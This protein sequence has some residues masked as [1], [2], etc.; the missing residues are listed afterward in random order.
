MAQQ[1]Q[2]VLFCVLASL[3]HSISYVGTFYSSS[4][5]PA[6]LCSV[7]LGLLWGGNALAG[8]L[9][10]S[11]LTKSLGLRASLVLSFS[12][13]AVQMGCL[14]YSIAVPSIGWPLSVCGSLYAG[15]TSAIW[16]DCQALVVEGACAVQSSADRGMALTSIRSN[17]NAVWTFTYQGVNMIIFLSLTFLMY[18]FDAP[19]PLLIFAL[20]VVGIV[21]TMV[22]VVL[23]I[24]GHVSAKPADSQSPRSTP[25]PSVDTKILHGTGLQIDS[26]RRSGADDGSHAP[27][28][29]W[30]VLALFATDYRCALLA[31]TQL[32]FGIAT[33]LF[34]F[35]VNATLI[36]GRSS[37][38]DDGNDVGVL[39]LGLLEAFAYLVS[40]LAAFPYSYFVKRYNALTLIMVWGN[41]SF[42]LAALFVLCVP[43]FR[44]KQWS[45]LLLLKGLYGA[46]RGVFEGENRSYY[47]AMFRGEKLVAAFSQ[48][49]FLTGLSGGVFFLLAALLS[50]AALSA[51]ACANGLL[52]MACMVLLARGVARRPV[53]P[54]DSKI[55]EDWG[56]HTLFAGVAGAEEND[57]YYSRLTDDEDIQ[58]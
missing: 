32:S 5:L 31:P 19:L 15:A 43:V 46:G 18:S 16:W 55:E 54:D 42:V 17:L 11:W 9:I 38:G 34:A 29:M 50:P 49:G 3:N 21:S 14:Y 37:S 22:V 2:F 27:A 1:S 7:S 51:V 57:S 48:Q 25:A 47:A 12:G 36:S 10:A 23:P 41:L 13:F 24:P 6:D 8:L 40:A 53:R 39:Y 58:V 44:L 35:F 52:A 20:F 45:W 56:W 4:L 28:S 26:A 33:T 30:D